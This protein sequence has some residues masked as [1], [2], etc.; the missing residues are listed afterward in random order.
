[1]IKAREFS[2]EDIPTKVNWMNNPIIN[3][4]MFFELPATISKTE[5]WFK[6]K[7]NNTRVDFSFL[8]EQQEIVG[9]GGFT[10]IDKINSNAEY[11]I[12]V[13]PNLHGQGFGKK[14]SLWMFNYAFLKLNLNKIYL[15]TNDDNVAANK[16][17]ENSGF[18]LEGILREH[19]FKKGNFLNRRFYGLLKSEWKTKNWQQD[20]LQYEF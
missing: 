14:I 16:I 11:Y 2:F 18:K 15:Y 4:S 19:K 8:N 12:M 7:N 6:N 20:N 10:N 1:M 9:M 17:Y 3:N 13:N 5:T